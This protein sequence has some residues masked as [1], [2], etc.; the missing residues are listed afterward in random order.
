MVAVDIACGI[1]WSASCCT[2]S[3]SACYIGSDGRMA[4][5]IVEEDK[6]MAQASQTWRYIDLSSLVGLD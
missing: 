3:L 1:G 4:M 2:D 5:E 6:I